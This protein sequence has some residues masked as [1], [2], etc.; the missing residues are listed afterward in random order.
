MKRWARAVLCGVVIAASA[1]PAGAE[2]FKQVLTDAINN[3]PE[4]MTQRRVLRQLDETVAQARAGML[5][6]IT[7]SA[8]VGHTVSRSAQSRATDNSSPASIGLS[9]SQPLF[10]GWQTENAI[11]AAVANVDAGRLTLM[12]TEQSVALEAIEAYVA[13][14]Q[15]QETVRL[16]RSNVEVIARQLDATR[17]RLEVGEVT[18][19]DVA[20]AEAQLA[21]SRA[22]LRSNE[23]DLRSA[24]EEFERVVG[25]PPTNLEPLPQLPVMPSSREEAEEV[26]L[27][28]NPTYLAT[29]AAERAASFGVDQAYGALYPQVSVNGD[30]TSSSTQVYGSDGASVS[31]SATLTV[32]VPFYSGGAQRS[33]VRSSAQLVRQRAH[34]RETARRQLLRDVGVNWESLLT[35][36]ATIAANAEQVQAQQIAFRGVQEEA[37]VGSR[38]TLDVLNAEQDL[39]DARVALVNSRSD[40]QIA[41]Y[42]L[43]FSMGTLTSETLGLEV[44]RYDPVEPYNESQRFS[45]EYP[46]PEDDAWMENY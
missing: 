32:T 16:A 6:T 31:G 30:V 28:R 37:R 43:L 24:A 17:A 19:T 14:I 3:S 10:D 22:N 40:E 23:G 4:I 35:A 5:P 29:F 12:A 2:S 7:G 44:A 45:L 13:V 42:R 34:E 41:A 33:R 15:A 18:R 46:D 8:S 21:D 27:E 11:A 9:A 25:Y 38:T 36:R 26:A 1:A 20:Q 39:L